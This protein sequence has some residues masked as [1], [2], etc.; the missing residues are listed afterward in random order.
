MATN[1]CSTF[2]LV[3]ITSLPMSL[4]SNDLCT[5][6]LAIGCYCHSLVPMPSHCLLITEIQYDERPLPLLSPL[7]DINW[8]Y[9][10]A[11]PPLL[12]TDVQHYILS[13]RDSSPLFLLWLALID[14]IH[15]IK[16]TSP[17]P[18]ILHTVSDKKNWIVGRPGNEAIIKFFIS[19]VFVESDGSPCFSKSAASCF[20]RSSKLGQTNVP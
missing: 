18:S 10:Q 14:A 20:D 8:C 3:L 2:Y 11:I 7:V 13:I 4:L 1:V 15:V 12:I 16:R 19:V 6:A 9:S 17:S 5:L